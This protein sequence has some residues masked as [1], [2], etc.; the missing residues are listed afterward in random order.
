MR[1][2]RDTQTLANTTVTLRQIIGSPLVL[3]IS[4]IMLAAG[5]AVFLLTLATW[6]FHYV[7]N[8]ASR[9]LEALLRDLWGPWT[10]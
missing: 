6:P 9:L 5:F 1:K 7:Q 3:A 2:I 8:T 4:I 10:R